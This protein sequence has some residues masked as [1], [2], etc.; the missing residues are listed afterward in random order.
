MSTAEDVAKLRLIGADFAHH[1]RHRDLGLAGLNVELQRDLG[2]GVADQRYVFRRGIG[3]SG[4]RSDYIIAAGDREPT[5][6][7]IAAAARFGRSLLPG[8]RISDLNPHTRNAGLALVHHAAADGC[9]IRSLRVTK[10]GEGGDAK[11][12]K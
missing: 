10:E 11:E 3:E 9:G 7:E 1:A 12:S 6:G 8:L 4:F 5:H 2:R